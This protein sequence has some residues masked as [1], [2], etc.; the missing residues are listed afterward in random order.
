MPF[1]TLIFFIACK[2]NS[3]KLNVDKGIFFFVLLTLCQQASLF[4][5]PNEKIVPLNPKTVK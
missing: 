4:L 5:Q 1:F 3:L 2:Q